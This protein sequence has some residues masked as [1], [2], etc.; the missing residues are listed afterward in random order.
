MFCVEILFVAF[1][2]K[3]SGEIFYKIVIVESDLAIILEKCDNYS[4]FEN[5]L[6]TY[7]R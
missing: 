5:E 4:Q 6:R 7:D 2:F 3:N 1:S